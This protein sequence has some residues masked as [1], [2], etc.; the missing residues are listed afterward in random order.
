MPN[1]LI[2]GAAKSGTTALYHYLKQHPQIYMSPLKETNF[3]AFE[4]EK[5]DFCGPDDQ[6]TIN[7]YSV[8]NIDDYRALF[9]RVLNETAIGEASPWYLYIPRSSE[10]I[11]HYIPNVK[12]IAILRNPVESAYSSYLM[13]VRDGREKLTDFAQA[14]R[15]EKTRIQSNWSWGQYVS[16]GFYYTQLKRYFDTFSRSQIKVYLYEDLQVNAI[17]L[18]RDIFRFLSVDETFMP[19]LSIRYNVSVIPKNKVLHT[20]VKG[21]HSLMIEENSIKAVLKLLLPTGLQINLNQRYRNL[22]NQYVQFN[23]IKPQL[24]PAVRKQLSEVYREDILKLQ[25]LIQ[26]DL[27]QWL[28]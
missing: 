13:H 25:A 26:R 27:S 12:L 8:N 6:K 17:G 14:L 19:D 3:F 16:A 2:V 10:C 11:R 15:E 23:L 1:F 18:I 20:L 5:L 21:M 22:R 4:G 28:E 24:S 9:E 7:R